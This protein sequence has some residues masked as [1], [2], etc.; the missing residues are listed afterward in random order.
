MFVYTVH[1]AFL[2]SRNLKKF[3]GR[4]LTIKPTSVFF[5]LK[6]CLSKAVSQY[7][8]NEIV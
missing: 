2:T 7:G 4:F 3:A 8:L 5:G 6:C 1:Y